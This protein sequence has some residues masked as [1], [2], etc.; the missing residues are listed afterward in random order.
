MTVA[1]LRRGPDFCDTLEQWQQATG[2]DLGRYTRAELHVERDRLRWLLLVL[3]DRPSAR[4]DARLDWLT[5]R[6]A[7]VEARLR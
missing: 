4:N 7:Q 2:R 1:E 3:D 6:L 5:A